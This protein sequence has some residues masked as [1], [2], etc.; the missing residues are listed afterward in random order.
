M[1]GFPAAPDLDDACDAGALACA[2]PDVEVIAEAAA[3]V[4]HDRVACRA[5]TGRHDHTVAHDGD[6]PGTDHAGLSGGESSG[7]GN[8]SAST[9]LARALAACLM[10]CDRVTP[11]IRAAAST[12]T[13]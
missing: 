6:E 11:L 5:V 9:S 13:A 2:G 1:G 12:R 3:G 4:V 10:N 8:A 7:S